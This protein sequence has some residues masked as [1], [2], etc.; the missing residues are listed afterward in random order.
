M[1]IRKFKLV[2]PITYSELVNNLSLTPYQT[3]DGDIVFIKFSSMLPG[4][5]DCNLNKAEFKTSELNL[6][7]GDTATHASV[8]AFCKNKLIS[9]ILGNQAE[10]S[11]FGR[12]VVG[13]YGYIFNSVE[14]DYRNVVKIETISSGKVKIIQQGM[15]KTIDSSSIAKLISFDGLVEVQT[16]DSLE[17]PISFKV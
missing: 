2:V 14:F 5:L 1:G 10:H 3:K 17:L 13:D 6:L 9:S 11:S 7:Q 16:G 15:V 8:E 4:L 12:H